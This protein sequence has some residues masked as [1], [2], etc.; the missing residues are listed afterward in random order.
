M[1]V[2]RL[3]KKWRSDRPPATGKAGTTGRGSPAPS[4]PRP[5]SGGRGPA[6]PGL[7]IATRIVT[8]TSTEARTLGTARLALREDAANKEG[9]EDPKEAPAQVP[10]EAAAEVSTETSSP[11]V[12]KEL[13]EAVSQAGATTRRTPSRSTGTTDK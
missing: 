3:P 7:D 8:R 6:S 12:A 4:E 1:K 2:W 11:E 5:P 10:K 9:S 13:E